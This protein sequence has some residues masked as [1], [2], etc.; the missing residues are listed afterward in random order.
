MNMLLQMN[1]KNTNDPME[2]GQRMWT[3]HRKGNENEQQTCLNKEMK[4]R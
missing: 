4:I 1:W 2:N 3:V